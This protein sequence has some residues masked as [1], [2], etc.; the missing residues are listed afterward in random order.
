MQSSSA[1]FASSVASLCPGLQLEV[2][3]LDRYLTRLNPALE[4]Y[5]SLRSIS[6]MLMHLYPQV[7]LTVYH[8]GRIAESQSPWTGCFSSLKPF[9]VNI[10]IVKQ[11]G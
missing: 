8:H 6:A 3:K 7:Y 11:L 2:A 5:L 10:C 4:V 1:K 9:T